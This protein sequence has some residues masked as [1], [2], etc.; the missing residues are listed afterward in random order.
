MDGNGEGTQTPTTDSQ[1]STADQLTYW[2][3]I[4]PDVNGMLGGFPQVSRID[5]QFSRNFIHKLRRLDAKSG[6][7]NTNP[8]QN[9][10][11]A[12][13]VGEPDNKQTYVFQH[14]LEP[15]AGIGRVTLNLLALLCAK[16]DIIEPIEK[17][18]AVLT[19]PD[20]PLVK[21]Q[22]LTRVWNVPLQEWSAEIQPTYYND[23]S[24][25]KDPTTS[26]G[27]SS[28]EN[29]PPP[30][31]DLIFNQWCLNHLSFPSL[32]AYFKSLIPL[33]LLPNGWIIVKEN[34]STDAFGSDIFDAEDSSVTRSDGNWRGA[35]EEAGLKVVK[36]DLQTGFAKELGLYPVRIYAL[37]PL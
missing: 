27:G 33:L 22:Q 10:N 29:M 35:F 15:G 14:A 19:A 23:Y 37:R 36:T 17:F 26:N 6:P 2:Q 13:A 7:M 9:N 30:K 8:N 31:Y 5:V 34:L 28:V 18:T 3:N 32:V 1:I 16:I 25:A 20:S 12:P 4:D 21:Q 11:K 24:S